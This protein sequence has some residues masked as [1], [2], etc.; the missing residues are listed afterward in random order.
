M[1]K[2][3]NELIG[4]IEKIG[5]EEF[6]KFK[7]ETL[8]KPLEWKEGVCRCVCLQ[9]QSIE[10]INS[11]FVTGL[12]NT[13]QLLGKYPETN[14]QK[15]SDFQKY[16]FEVGYC[17]LCRPGNLSVDLKPIKKGLE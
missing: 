16:Y 8:N 6:E 4:Q 15:I 10:E 5:D 3:K 9:C 14:L 2:W 1:T 17:D 7:K 12:L 13:M 11:E